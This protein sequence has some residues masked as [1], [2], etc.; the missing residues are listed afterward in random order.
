MKEQAFGDLRR[1]AD[2]LAAPSIATPLWLGRV[3]GK[4]GR[5]A[6]PLL[7]R[8]L[9]GTSSDAREAARRAVV[10]L[11]A[12]VHDDDRPRVIAELRAIADDA[13]ACDDAKVC[14]VG[15]LGELGER[16]EARFAN[17][18]AIRQRSA[19]AL[20]AH[21]ET[22]SEIASAVD[23]M[24]RTL[25]DAEIADMIEAM[26]EVAPHAAARL[27]GELG[28]RLDASAELH[29]RV[30][31]GAAA[32]V[33]PLRR[34]RPAKASVL[35]DAAARLVVVAAR[36]V[37]GERRWRRWAVLIGASGRIDDCLHADA[38]NDGE[39]AALVDSLVDQGYR[40]ASTDADHARA[41][42]S[43]AARLTASE[44]GATLCSAY[45]VGR[46]L[47]E[48]GDDHLDGRPRAATVATTLGRAV[49]LI[50]TGDHARA[51]PLLA[52]CDAS[53]P[54]VAAALAAC[55]V[56]DGRHADAIPHLARACDGDREWPLHHWNLAAS[57]HALGDV[58]SCALALRNFLTASESPTGLDA[59]P[60]HPSRVAIARRWVADHERVA[61]LLDKPRRRRSR[62]RRA[63]SP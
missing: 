28:C 60:D 1:L 43:A 4:L 41:I 13:A 59:D 3:L 14:A 38:A 7:G 36:R 31:G 57:L 63:K 23:L 5:T 49:D 40:V 37:P 16:G 33:E 46:D 22:P 52:R 39:A 27:A 53:S 8:A 45:Y 2:W 24:L 18:L 56:A 29:A 20:A 9:R 30:A 19:L 62:S 25:G 55:H 17:P 48:L 44:R 35:V 10:A 15:L 34:E 6:V 26:A 12:T 61:R 21:L 32:P 47:L 51:L 11:G 50:A 58:E 54:D 42:V